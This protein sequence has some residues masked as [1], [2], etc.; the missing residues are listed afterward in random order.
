MTLNE[1]ASDWI[2]NYQKE[3]IKLQTYVRYK[4]VIRTHIQDTIGN[5]NIC[6]FT[7]KT[8]QD[9][10]NDVM[11]SDSGRTNKPLSA[12]SVNMILTTLKLIFGYAVDFDLLPANPTDRVRGAG[13]EFRNRTKFFTK[14][15]QIYIEKY[16]YSKNNPEWFGVILV[17]YTG[18]RIGELMALEWRDIDLDSGIMAITKTMYSSLNEQ[19]EWEDMIDTPKTR[20]SYRDIPLPVHILQQL[21]V[22]KELSKSKRVVAHNNGDKLETSLFRWRFD[23]MLNDLHMVHRSFHALRHTFATRAIENGMDVKTLAEILG[24]ANTSVTLNVYAHSSDEHKR[25]AMNVMKPLV[26]RGTFASLKPEVD[27][28]T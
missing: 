8:I 9:F 10:I 26:S 3:H 5:I 24:H 11:K 28:E 17:L 18:I 23:K 6:D 12:S 7:K 14:E 15:E 25:I 4:S 27:R 21:R 16:I 13:S 20:T 2:E 22:L 19:G 1:L